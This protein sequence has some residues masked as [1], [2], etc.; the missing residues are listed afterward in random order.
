MNQIAPIAAP[1]PVALAEAVRMK[2]SLP[3]LR[4]QYPRDKAEAREAKKA[5]KALSTPPDELW[6]GQRVVTLLYHYFVGDLPDGAIEAMAADWVAELSP[7]PEWAIEAA[8]AWWLSRGNEYRHRKPM[9]GDISAVAHREAGLLT[10][11]TQLLS[12]YEK[13]G[14]R[15][16]SYLCR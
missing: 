4:G 3:V 2:G 14:D 11:A 13:Y 16:P 15:P 12:A 9:P 8:C 6:I 10:C 1:R 7:Y 5:I